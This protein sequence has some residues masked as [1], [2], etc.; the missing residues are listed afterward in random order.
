MTTL[1]VSWYFKMGYLLRTSS[2]AY[3]TTSLTRAMRCA[4]VICVGFIGFS[5]GQR[6]MRFSMDA[7]LRVRASET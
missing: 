3:N 2:L 5:K 6:N 4:S 1:M 7:I